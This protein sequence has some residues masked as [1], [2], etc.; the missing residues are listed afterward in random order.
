MGLRRFEA[1][2]TECTGKLTGKCGVLVHHDCQSRLAGGRR[3]NDHRSR[4]PRQMF[5]SPSTE[6]VSVRTRRQSAAS[7]IS[8]SPYEGIISFNLAFHPP[9]FNSLGK[10]RSIRLIMIQVAVE[11]PGEAPKSATSEWSA[12]A[13]SSVPNSRIPR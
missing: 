9:A 2:I 6:A 10:Q 7:S 11:A 1:I 5:L 13:T 4:L 12:E 8:D 3:L